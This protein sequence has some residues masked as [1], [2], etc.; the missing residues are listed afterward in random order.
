[1]S[2]VK[3]STASEW[4][5]ATDLSSS[6]PRPLTLPSG[7]TIQVRQRGAIAN[8][9]KGESAL[10]TII[11]TAKAQQTDKDAATAAPAPLPDQADIARAS[12][13]V[14]NTVI[15]HVIEPKIVRENPGPG[16]I[17]LSSIRDD[18]DLVFIF[19]D[20][21]G[22]LAPESSPKLAQTLLNGGQNLPSH[23]APKFPGMRV[24]GKRRK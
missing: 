9:V 12:E 20:A 23:L 6:M 24:G 3:I 1:M 13:F 10:N 16:E 18:R 21:T 11:S 8:A 22:N 19:L 17:L 14:V 5:N 2:T 4:A 15:D 7:A